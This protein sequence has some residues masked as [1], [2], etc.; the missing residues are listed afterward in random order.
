MECGL[1]GLCGSGEC[2]ECGVWSVEC[3]VWSVECG[4]WS[5]EW[6]VLSKSGSGSGR[7]GG[8]KVGVVLRSEDRTV[9]R[10]VKERMILF[11]TPEQSSST[12]GPKDEEM[13]SLIEGRRCRC[14]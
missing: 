14:R 13:E 10:R 8:K 1:C 5:V 2:V 3:G 12:K 11:P 6:K 9:I 4:V 7:G